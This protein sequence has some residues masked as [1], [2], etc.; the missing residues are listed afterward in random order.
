MSKSTKTFFDQGAD[1]S[2][3]TPFD[4]SSEGSLRA[5]L[6]GQIS[7]GTSKWYGVYDHLGDKLNPNLISFCQWC[8]ENAFKSSEVW[9]GRKI[10]FLS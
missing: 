7:D 1:T 5:C 3:F 6:G 2:I 8:G 10:N 9:S 4:R